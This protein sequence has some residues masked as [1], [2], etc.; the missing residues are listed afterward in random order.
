MMFPCVIILKFSAAN[1]EK[2][3]NPPQKP[4]VR[5]R[6]NELENIS[7]SNKAMKIPIN[8]QPNIFAKKV[9]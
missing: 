7:F 4:I 3:V 6:Y 9:P 5:N 1:D 8:R 2:V